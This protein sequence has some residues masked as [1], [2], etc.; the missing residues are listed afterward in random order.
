MSDTQRDPRVAGMAEK[1]QE[2]FLSYEPTQWR[3]I[4]WV[5]RQVAQGRPLSAEQVNHRIAELEIAPE[6][7]HQILRQ[8]TEQDADGA[9]V[10]AFGLSQCDHPHR[11]TVAGVSLSAWCALDSLFLPGLLQQTLTIESL[12]PVTHQPV[13]LGVSPTRVEAV[14]PLS[15]VVSFALA[16]P[17]RQ[18]LASVEAILGTYCANIHFFATRDEAEQWIA[19]REELTVLTVDE[20]FAWQRRVWS[21]VLP[22]D[23][24]TP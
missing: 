20:A 22:D 15:A 9:I 8:S 12:S 11:V 16:D 6:T 1:M 3:L 21:Q 14:N 13:H 18:D 2:Y 23:H 17:S 5:V 4:L 10:G 24:T 19:G 7:A